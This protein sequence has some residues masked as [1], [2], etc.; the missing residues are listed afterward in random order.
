V[1]NNQLEHLKSNWKLDSASDEYFKSTG[2]AQIVPENL[3]GGGGAG[4][5]GGGGGGGGGVQDDVDISVE[6]VPIDMLD[7][8]A[9]AMCISP[10]NTQPQTYTCVSIYTH[11]CTHT[12]TACIYYIYMHTHT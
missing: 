2:E 10:T 3:K 11:T 4:G 9:G 7:P 5:A 8:A 1:E 6:N 12:H